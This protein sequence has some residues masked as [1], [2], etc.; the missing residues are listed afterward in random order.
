MKNIATIRRWSGI[1]ASIAVLGALAV[2]RAA[3]A[4][5][6]LEFF[7]GPMRNFV[8]DLIFWGDFSEKERNDVREY[9][10]QFSAFVNGTSPSI[11]PG[12]EAAVHYYGVSGVLPGV[13]INDPTPIF[14]PALRGG[15]RSLSNTDFLYEI[16]QAQ[17]G[18]YGY[19]SNIVGGQTIFGPLPVGPNRLAVVMTKGT[20][21]LSDGSK[22]IPI[23]GTGSSAPAYHS[24]FNGQIYAPVMVDPGGP[25]FEDFTIN[26]S[27]EIVEAMTDPVGQNGWIYNGGFFALHDEAADDC[28]GDYSMPWIATS[29]TDISGVTQLTLNGSFGGVNNIPAL[30]CQAFEPME[31]APMTVVLDPTPAGVFEELFFRTPD[32]RIEELLWT[33]PTAPVQSF[34]DWGMPIAGSGGVTA[35]GKPSAVRGFNVGETRL[36]TRGSDSAVYMLTV[37]SGTGQSQWT[38]IGGAL[39]GDPGA[40]SWTGWNGAAINL[41]G[42]GTDDRLYTD[43][44][45]PDATT[46]WV[47]VPNSEGVAFVGSPRPISSRPSTIDVFVNGENGD[48]WRVPYSDP[49]GWTSAQDIGGVSDGVNTSSVASRSPVSAISVLP[50]Y[51][52]VLGAADQFFAWKEQHGGGPWGGGAPFD[53]LGDGTGASGTPAIVM[54]GPERADGFGI[55][56]QNNLNHAVYNG[57]WTGDPYPL[58]TDAVGDPVAVTRGSPELDVFYRNTGRGITHMHYDGTTWHTE[59]VWWVTVQ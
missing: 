36:F 3:R 32:G 34:S 21:I 12:F 59:I 2:P 45:L 27:H 10:Q 47:Q 15:Y 1:A 19:A 35:A 30:S 24:D 17:S 20:N 16:E 52:T 48:V 39:F 18:A 11:P 37:N 8:I 41:F 42:I 55:D 38:Y 44:F 40:V 22:G 9:V 28:G 31:F 6:P 26:L 53:S 56:R 25:G 46:G 13:Y 33:D 29:G 50:G 57:P 14:A 54:W 51:F 49:T 5:G 23:I 7:G 58:A 4:H 43:T